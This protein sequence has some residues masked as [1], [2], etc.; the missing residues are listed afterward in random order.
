MSRVP[1][2]RSYHGSRPEIHAEIPASVCPEDTS[3]RREKSRSTVKLVSPLDGD[4]ERAGLK[5]S[6][7]LCVLVYVGPELRR[8]RKSDNQQYMNTLIQHGPGDPEQDRPE[9]LYPDSERLVELELR[10]GECYG[11]WESHEAEDRCEV[12][13]VHGAVNN[14]RTKILLDTGVSVSMISLDLARRLRL[15][16]RMRDPTRVSGFGGSPNVHIGKCEN[17][18]YARPKDCVR[19]DVYVAN[20]GEGLEVLFRMN[21]MYAAG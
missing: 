14:S 12:A 10:P 9:W 19:H 2:S 15:K 21:F 7:V 3:G 4:P 11:W 16:L 20:I 5:R 18:D 8:R 1:S 17:Q 6:Q 13:T